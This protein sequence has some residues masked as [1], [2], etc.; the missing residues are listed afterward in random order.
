MLA[1]VRYLLLRVDEIG[2]TEV[3]LSPVRGTDSQGGDLIRRYGDVRY[4]VGEHKSYVCSHFDMIV[5][6]VLWIH[7]INS[8]PVGRSK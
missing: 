1:N 6:R 2:P 5:V 7:L 4:K 3:K 8:E